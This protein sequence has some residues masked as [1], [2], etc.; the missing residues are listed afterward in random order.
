M[1]HTHRFRSSWARV[2]AT[3][4]LAAS[5]LAALLGGC[6]G[7]VGT[8]GTGTY[9]AGPITGYGSIVVNNV[10]FDD[11]SASVLDDD[12]GARTRSELKLGMT[13]AID[14]DAIRSEAGGRAATAWRIRFGSELVAP[15]T[16]VDVA[17]GTLAMLG[18][19][20]RVT[21][22][23]VLDERLAGGLA[24]ISAAQVLE[25]YALYDATSGSYIATRIE[26]RLAL[27][28]WHLRG[29]V[30][31]LDTAQRS[32]R[33]GGAS[34]SYANAAGV[35]ADLAV[36]RIVRVRVG[37]VAGPFGGYFVS[38]FGVGVRAPE[39]RDDAELKGLI[40]SFASATA[41]SI[42]GLSVDASSATFPDGSVGL[43][44]GTRVEVE[45]SL[46]A[47]VLRATRVS[48]ETDEQLRERGFDIKGSITAVDAAAK[49][50]T[51]RGETLSWARPDLQLDDGTLADIAV[52]REVE[53]KA[54][55]SILRTRLE[56][57]RIKFK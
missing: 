19:T 9:A 48:I 51:L 23:T 41:F 46:H 4:L 17:A 1:H 56:A 34:F 8:G 35:P 37:N 52:G 16:G 10:H 32:V 11:S 25:V 42:N 36:G 27:A 21:Q 2:A 39:D 54:Q 28:T 30:A 38:A 50:L 49:T 3:L 5:S 14:S 6:G 20:V 45:G 7:G 12:D 55:L 24:G 18:Q 47:G 15:V 33:I 22:D 53:V 44:L 13:V 29:P 26:P 31:E 40:T 57:T 43:R